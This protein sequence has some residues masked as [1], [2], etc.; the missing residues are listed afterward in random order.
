MGYDIKLLDFGIDIKLDHAILV[1]TVH[2]ILIHVREIEI[3]F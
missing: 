1:K 2:F 3:L